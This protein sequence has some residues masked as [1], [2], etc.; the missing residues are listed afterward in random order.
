MLGWQT[1]KTV[2]ISYVIITSSF[3]L[4]PQENNFHR[5]AS[6]WIFGIYVILRRASDFASGG[7]RFLLF[8]GSETD[9]HIKQFVCIL[10]CLF[11]VRSMPQ[12][13]KVEL[14]N[15]TQEEI[16][17][18][19]RQFASPAGF[20]ASRS[21]CTRPSLFPGRANWRLRDFCVNEKACAF[22]RLVIKLAGCFYWI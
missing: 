19:S 7:T 20:G 9:K 21:R 2:S 6:H 15:L 22:R 14:R 18:K 17:S 13:Q 8:R 1:G 11:W 10:R 4:V 12:L 5:T 16:T 3:V